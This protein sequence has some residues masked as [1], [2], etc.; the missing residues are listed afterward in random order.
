MMTLIND[1]LKSAA[2][3]Q[4]KKE[5]ALVTGFLRNNPHLRLSDITVVYRKINQGRYMVYVKEKTIQDE[6]R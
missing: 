1:Y 3:E 6:A 5:Q 4:A 2:I